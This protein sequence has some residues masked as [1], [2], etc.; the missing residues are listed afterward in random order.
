VE[1]GV[2][3]LGVF[4][5]EPFL[6]LAPEVQSQVRLLSLTSRRIQALLFGLISM[7][8]LIFHECRQRDKNAKWSD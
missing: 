8:G 5:G 3:H 4:L 2:G 6:H 1:V 7:G